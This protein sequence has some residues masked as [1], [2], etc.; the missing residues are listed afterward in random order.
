MIVT[1]LVQ[2]CTACPS[3]WEGELDNGDEFYVRYRHGNF[4]V[5][6]NGKEVIYKEIN[7]MADGFMEEEEMLREAGFTLSPGVIKK[8]LYP[9]SEW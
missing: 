9:G 4:T 6:I 3:Q 8:P 1:K 2:T 5:D 7:R